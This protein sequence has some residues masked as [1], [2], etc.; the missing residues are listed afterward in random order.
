MSFPNKNREIIQ[1]VVVK[2][3]DVAR[4]FAL[5]EIKHSARI[6][7]IKVGA[8]LPLVVIGS[9]TVKREAA[10]AGSV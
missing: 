4:I 7:V 8:R 5:A 1:T 6:G 9:Q 10:A 3:G 2:Q